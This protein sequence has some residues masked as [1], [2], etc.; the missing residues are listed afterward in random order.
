[1]FTDYVKF[2]VP[3]NA[4]AMILTVVISFYAFPLP[5]PPPLPTVMDTVLATP[6]LSRLAALVQSPGYEA[7]AAQWRSTGASELTLFAPTDSAWDVIPELPDV[8]TMV[9]GLYYHTATVRAGSGGADSQQFAPSLMA[10]ASWV[11][12]GTN[13]PQVL[14]LVREASAMRVVFGVP[15]TVAGTSHVVRADVDCSNGYVHVVDRVIAIP[16]KLS[17]AA[18]AAGLTNFTSAL[19]LTG[20]TGE[21]DT[22]VAVTMFAPSDTAFAALPGWENDVAL[23]EAYLRTG[24]VHESQ[25]RYSPSLSD[26]D[27]LVS[28]NGAALE[29]RKDDSGLAVNGAAVVLRDLLLQNGVLHTVDSVLGPRAVSAV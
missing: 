3:L 14:H 13:V 10:N 16:P 25:P 17:V 21:F 8:G 29:I 28:D 19:R 23:L 26:G 20:L 24:L 12:L 9:E 7:V 27:T 22:N 2:G 18:A 1:M 5:P 11:H 15:N 6:E 4:L